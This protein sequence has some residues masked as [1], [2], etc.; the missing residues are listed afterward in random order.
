MRR[1]RAEAWCPLRRG[2]VG[3]ANVGFAMT[4]PDTMWRGNASFVLRLCL[5]EEQAAG[6]EK[7]GE[8]GGSNLEESCLPG[9]VVCPRIIEEIRDN[10]EGGRDVSGERHDEGK[11]RVSTQGVREG[12]VRI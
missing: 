2:G 7:R 3:A 10:L 5:Y 4:F 6:D 11:G 9:T 8:L 12:K 1:S